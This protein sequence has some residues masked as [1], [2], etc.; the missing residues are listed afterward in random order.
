[1]TT[2]V[3][4]ESRLRA[5]AQ[6][7]I[8]VLYFFLAGILAHHGAQGL[9]SDEWVPLVEKGMLAFL[10]ILGYASLGYWL[11]GQKYPVRE[12]GWPLRRD[13]PREAGLGLAVGWAVAVICVLPMALDGGIAIVL[14]TRLSS[15]GWLAVDTAFFALM[16]VVEEVAFRGYGF[17]RFIQAVGPVGATLGFAVYYAIV[18]SLLPGSSHAS[19]AVAMALS[20]V[21]SV[22]YLRTRALWM[23][24]GLNFGWKASR[25]LIFGLAVTGLNNHSP[26]VQGNPMAPFWATGGGFGLDGSWISFVVLLAALAAVFPMT[27]ELDFRY[28]APEIVPAGIPVDLEAAGRAQ[29]EAAMVA[30]AAPALVQIAPASAPE[31]QVEPAP[32]IRG[33]E[34]E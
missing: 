1:M 17:Q 26:I 22:V 6:F 33:S 2:A 3:A 18:E 13:W 21:L 23:S 15:W 31:A 28:N 10:L 32:I 29:H 25:G 8:A 12:Q 4:S 11:N 30:E 24:W 16:A 27:R 20:L 7:V 5:Y 14:S 9:V 19:F 34:S